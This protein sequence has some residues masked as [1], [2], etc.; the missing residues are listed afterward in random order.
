MPVELNAAQRRVATRYSRLVH[1]LSGQRIARELG[2][3]AQERYAAMFLQGA[4][5]AAQGRLGNLQ[6]PRAGGDAAALDN[7]DESAQ[8]R[9]IFERS[10]A[11]CE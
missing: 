9:E 8:Q 5:L 6:A 10:H 4:Q 3:A 2:I 7:A 1:D 11:V